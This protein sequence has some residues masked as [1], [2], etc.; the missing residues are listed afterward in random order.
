MS[1]LLRGLCTQVSITCVFRRVEDP[2]L[3]CVQ[4][5]RHF[6]MAFT[7]AQREISYIFAAPEMMNYQWDEPATAQGM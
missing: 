2:V 1:F 3:M 6:G 4:A 7:Y 5:R